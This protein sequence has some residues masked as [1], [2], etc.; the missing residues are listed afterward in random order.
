MIDLALFSQGYFDGPLGLGI[1]QNSI[2]MFMVLHGISSALSGDVSGPI[3]LIFYCCGT[4][5]VRMFC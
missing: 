3:S 4:I 5:F 1:Q 2:F